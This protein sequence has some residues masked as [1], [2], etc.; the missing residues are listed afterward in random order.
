MKITKTKGQSKDMMPHIFIDKK[1]MNR[2][3]K[4]KLTWRRCID[5][6]PSSVDLHPRYTEPSLDG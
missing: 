1:C 6:A 2:A 5:G 3:D 4:P